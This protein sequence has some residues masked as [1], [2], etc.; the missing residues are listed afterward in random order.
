MPAHV[1]TSL[2]VKFHKCLKRLPFCRRARAKN[3][4]FCLTACLILCANTNHTQTGD[5]CK[6]TEWLAKLAMTTTAS[7][8]QQGLQ[9][10]LCIAP[11]SK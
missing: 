2:L 3:S 1:P 9:R 8:P 10:G 11:R 7:S 5:S 6:F 4:E